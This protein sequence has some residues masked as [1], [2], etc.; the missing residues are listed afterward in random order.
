MLTA[1]VS[2]LVGGLVSWT[3]GNSA[4]SGAGR[5]LLIVVLASA[6]TYGIGVLFGTAIA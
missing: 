5:Q 4:L 3:A 6:V 2:L 1:I